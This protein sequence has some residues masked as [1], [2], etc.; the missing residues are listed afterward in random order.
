VTN[1]FGHGVI[2]L[3]VKDISEQITSLIANGTADVQAFESFS[4]YA[5]ANLLSQADDKIYKG[6]CQNVVTYSACI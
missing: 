6:L 5:R 4:L 2:I 1:Y 3:K